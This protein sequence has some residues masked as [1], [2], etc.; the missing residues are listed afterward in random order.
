MVS[1]AFS[2]I[3][4]GQIHNQPSWISLLIARSDLLRSW[5]VQA[6]RSDRILPKSYPRR[7]SLLVPGRCSQLTTQLHRR[8]RY[9]PYRDRPRSLS[10]TQGRRF[11]IH[12]RHPPLILRLATFHPPLDTPA[13]PRHPPP[14]HHPLLPPSTHLS[15]ILLPHPYRLLHHHRDRRMELCGAEGGGLGL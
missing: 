12:P 1:F 5:G 2:S 11:R 15:R 6:R 3:L 14:S 10:R 4:T 8:C 9:L 13:L 7:V